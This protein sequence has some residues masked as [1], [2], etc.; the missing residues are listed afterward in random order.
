[1]RN[2]ENSSLRMNNKEKIDELLNRTAQILKSLEV[3][4]SNQIILDKKIDV[5]LE[6]N[7]LAKPKVIVS[8]NS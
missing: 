3:L 7:N 2:S 1:M 6:N 4:S 5:I 8:D